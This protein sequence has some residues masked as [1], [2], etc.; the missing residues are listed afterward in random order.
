MLNF[1]VNR[2]SYALPKIYEHLKGSHSNFSI[3]FNDSYIEGSQLVNGTKVPLSS[4]YEEA[5]GITQSIER[6]AVIMIVDEPQ[7]SIILYGCSIVTGKN[8]IIVMFES[9]TIEMNLDQLVMVDLYNKKHLFLNKNDV[10]QGNCNCN[11]TE[12][13][14]AACF[15]RQLGPFNKDAD[16]NRMFY[17]YL[18]ITLVMIGLVY[19]I[20]RFTEST[21]EIQ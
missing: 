13:D 3:I 8:V 20:H 16:I 14:A 9:K 17:I 15:Y 4:K 7:V 19:C 6:F 21:D 1:P 5:C 12:Q 10:N 18:C 11:S 2:T